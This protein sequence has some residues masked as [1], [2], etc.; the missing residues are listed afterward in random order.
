ME[1]AKNP[2]EVWNIVNDLNKQKE[3]QKWE[4]NEDGETITDEKQVTGH[5]KKVHLM[6]L[7]IIN[8][9]TF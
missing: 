6:D 1:E 2:S 4:L 9:L 7:E 8:F 5:K 3:E